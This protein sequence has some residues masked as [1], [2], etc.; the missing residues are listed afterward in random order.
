MKIRLLLALPFL[1]FLAAGCSKQD[2]ITNSDDLI[3]TW[4]V[5][6]IQSNSA[7]D[8][9]GDG[10]IE[11]D[12]FGTYNSCQRD[13]VLVFDQAGYGQTRQGCNAPWESLQWQLGGNNSQLDIFMNSGD[14][15]LDIEQFNSNTIRGAD[16]VTVDGRQVR[17]TYTL[18]RR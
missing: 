5:G 17:I 14:I 10:R 8:W 15:N 4:Y 7:Y 9:D 13:I 11:T 6:A 1:F 16:Y 12:V 3:G 2:S 18:Y